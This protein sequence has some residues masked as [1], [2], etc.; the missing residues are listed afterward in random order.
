MPFQQSALAPMADFFAGG[1][2]DEL[3]RNFGQALAAAG[4]AGELEATSSGSSLSSGISSS[5][6]V[7]QAFS[8]G[9]LGCG[10]ASRSGS[11]GL[12]EAAAA[13]KIGEGAPHLLLGAIIFGLG[14]AAGA[15]DLHFFEGGHIVWLAA[16]E[17]NGPLE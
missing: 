17:K 13:P 5:L 3:G 14:D 16:V 2:G 11:G 4:I 1:G 7:Q 6:S 15:V 12:S 9:E 8:G 10:S